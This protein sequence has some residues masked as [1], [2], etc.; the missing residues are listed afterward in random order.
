[1]PSVVHN[2][3]ASDIEYDGHL[4]LLIMSE[5]HETTEGGWW[6]GSSKD[7]LHMTVHLGGGESGGFS[8]Y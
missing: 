7:D 4:D 5:A 1:M 3:I 8:E 2:V 6:G